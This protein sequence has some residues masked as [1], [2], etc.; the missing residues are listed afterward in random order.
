M[1]STLTITIT[2]YITSCHPTLN[3]IE[4]Q[5]EYLLHSSWHFWLSGTQTNNGWNF[6]FGFAYNDHIYRLKLT[7]TYALFSFLLILIKTI[8]SMHTVTL[9]H[10]LKNPLLD[11]HCFLNIG[12]KEIEKWP[13]DEDREETNMNSGVRH[14]VIGR[15]M[16]GCWAGGRTKQKL[17]VSW[18]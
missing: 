9:F 1:A 2:W 11:W 18:R 12:H 17:Q 8:N 10:F 4:L 14:L 7:H 15:P 6:T 13:N 5:Q 16:V 3:N